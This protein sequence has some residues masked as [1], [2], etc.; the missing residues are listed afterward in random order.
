MRTRKWGLVHFCKEILR[1]RTRHQ[2]WTCPLFR[3][4]RRACGKGDRSIFR[5]RMGRVQFAHVKNGP[6]PFS[7][8]T[9]LEI[10]LALA[11]LAGALAVL[12]EV[13][14]LAD[15]RASMTEG[16]TQAQILAASVMDELACGA[17]ELSV[18]SQAPLDPD[19]DPPWLYSVSVENTDLDELVAVRVAVEQQLDA[20][21][22]PARFEFVRWMPNRDYVPP[23]SSDESSSST[24]S[25]STFWHLIRKR[26]RRRAA[27]IDSAQKSRKRGLVHFC[28]ATLRR[29]ARHQKWT[30]PLFRIERRACRKGDRSIFRRHMGRVQFAHVK[31][32]P[33]P[34]SRPAF[35]LFEL[36]LAIALSAV[37][38]SLIG[39]AINL[40]LMRVDADRTR[41]EEAQLARSV[42]AMIADDIRA[43]AIYQPQDTSAIAQLMAAGT[44]F[45]V[46]SIDDARQAS[47]S[48]S[49]LGSPGGT[50]AVGKVASLSGSSSSA[51]SSKSSGGSSS[52]GESSS[53]ESEETMPLGLSGTA[54]E[55]YVDV[56]RLP[57]LEEL[58]ATVTGYTNAPSATSSNPG[59]SGS[60]T[61]AAEV[62]P[63]ADLKTI[64]YCVRP[65]NAVGPVNTTDAAL[66][67]EA[68]SNA[69]GL[70]RQEIPRRMRVF[71]E[72]AGTSDMSVT[73]EVLVAP[74][75]VQVQF[76]YFDGSQLTDVWEMKELNKL[77]VAIEVRVWLRSAR[78]AMAE[79]DFSSEDELASVREYRQIV[80][81]PMA[82]LSDSGAASEAEGSADESGTGSSSASGSSSGSGSAFGEP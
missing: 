79:S 9:L 34:F 62:N 29:R 77:P 3:M 15:Q 60:G 4:E 26:Q 61:A 5:R 25:S 74:E 32:G 68:Q 37:L 10:I 24:S 42:L 33:V 16:E 27:M 30:C 65:S 70:V 58:F 53:E 54:E 75:V 81:L 17:R 52:S 55:L 18:V 66:A 21:L 31:N 63:P 71:A 20:R 38:L 51:S 49:N 76:Q 39:T 8:F 56:T 19:S 14:R 7:A 43:A 64:H 59:G 46:D 28:D 69:G 44:P 73:G 36:I 12:G 47:S 50:G 45:D 40:Y 22:Q 6:V 2:K 48:P 80:Y 1:R 67:P 78:I 11:I 72:Q 57:R 13:M 41:V 82:A 23:E 35:T